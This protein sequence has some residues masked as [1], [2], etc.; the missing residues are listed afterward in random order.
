MNTEPLIVG[1]GPT[2]LAAALFLAE[3]GIRARLIERRR[4]RTSKSKAMGINPRTLKL[5]EGTGVT[6]RLLDR[7]RR[8]T[9]A[10]FYRNGDRF[11]RLDLSAAGGD[12]PFM[13]VYPQSDTEAI[14]AEAL[15][16]RGVEVERCAELIDVDPCGA[17]AVL[18]TA[19]GQESV[20]APYILAADGASSTL[21]RLRKIDFP[22]FAYE[23]SWKLY[24]VRLRLPLDPDE[25][26]IFL[27]DDGVL[28]LLRFRDDVWRAAGNVPDL[29]AR[30]PDGSETGEVF[31]ESDFHI[32]NRIAERFQTGGVY[33]AG[34]AAHVHSPL[35]ARGMNLGIEDAYVFAAL[36]ADDRLGD[37]EAIR[38]P[39]DRRVVHGVA[40]MTAVPRGR[41]I[42]GR[43]ARPLAPLLGR[44]LP[45]AGGAVRRWLLGLDHEVS[46]R[47]P[48]TNAT[49]GRP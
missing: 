35:G 18:G 38:R 43:L 22:G 3:H 46:L 47:P 40:R 27:L 10:N 30:L 42:P 26:H 20:R 17:H 23:E 32:S 15:A 11:A 1:A 24:D 49:P 33:L 41:S 6:A 39:V 2:G 31:W 16:E 21:R 25:V 37:Y 13:L 5:L 28:F 9:A 12:Y 45:L 8:V 44:L 48:G 14:L 4:S 29:L 34:D 7:G 19:V 36:A